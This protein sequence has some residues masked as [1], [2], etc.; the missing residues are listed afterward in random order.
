[1]EVSNEDI[2]DVR[3][4]P[5]KN[6]LF[7]VR[8]GERADGK[9]EKH[10]SDSEITDRGKDQ[11]K[12][13]ASIIKSIVEKSD[14]H[15]IKILSSPW[16]RCLMTS[17]YIANALGVS[18]V[19]IEPKISESLLEIG[20]GKTNPIPSLTWR[21]ADSSSISQVYFEDSVEIVFPEEDK[22]K[23]VEKLFPEDLNEYYIRF[24]SFYE[25]F[26]NS[27]KGSVLILVTHGLAVES[28]RSY[29]DAPNSL[30]NYW[31]ISWAEYDC[32]DKT[33]KP[34]SLLNCYAKHIDKSEHYKVD[35]T[36]G[37]F[38]F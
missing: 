19:S 29:T 23:E 4:H 12:S 20:F 32:E 5:G 9:S 28:F 18:S 3:I 7:V 15:H 16:L 8:H 11:A 34:R 35:K 13:T 14:E 17:S 6:Y 33:S 38:V 31:C 2:E 36:F 22:F 26:K 1:M 27:K 10:S 37:I 21:N 24:Q 30:I 25:D